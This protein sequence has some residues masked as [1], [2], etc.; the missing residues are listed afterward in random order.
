MGAEVPRHPTGAYPH[1]GSCEKP[2]SSLHGYLSIAN[3]IPIHG[4]GVSL[5]PPSKIQNFASRGVRR[6]ERPSRS[7]QHLQEPDGVTWI[8]RP[9]AMLSLPNHTKGPIISLVQ[10]TSAILDL[11]LQRALHHVRLLLHWSLN[12][13]EAEL[14]P[15]N[16]QTTTI[17]EPKVLRPKVQC[18][19]FKGGRPKREVRHHR[20]RR[21]TRST[22]KGPDIF[23]LKESTRNHDRGARQRREVYQRRG[24][25]YIKKGKRFCTQGKKQRREKEGAKQLNFQSLIAQKGTIAQERIA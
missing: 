15:A 19:V 3:R 11:V 10:Q 8:P 2:D 7:P 17:G 1:E 4:R 12:I 6:N 24:S 5:P 9:S 22:I 18:I 23:H 16:H 21:R 25:P 13:Q 20:F 14:S